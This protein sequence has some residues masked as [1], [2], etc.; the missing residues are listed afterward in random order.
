MHPILRLPATV[1]LALLAI[2]V[3]A[4]Q[5]TSYESTG[6]QQLPD[7]L[8]TRIQPELFNV[9]FQTSYIYQY[10]PG[11]NAAYS[12]SNSLSTTK[13]SVNSITATLFVGLRLWKGAELYINPELAGGSGLSGDKGMAGSANGETFRI[14]NLAPQLYLA[15]GYIRQTFPL[16]NTRDVA[17][18]GNRQGVE[19]AQ[20]Q[21]A[22]Y[23]PLNYLRFYLGKLSLADLFDNNTIGNS[24]RTQ[25][26]NWSFM[27]NGAWDFAANTR[28]Y[29]YVLAMEL[30]QHKTNYKIAAAAL[31]VVANGATLNTNFAN[32]IS[33]NAE[34]ATTTSIKNR[35]GHIRLLGFFNK[36]AMGSYQQSLALAP[37]GQRP[38][39]STQNTINGKLGF[40]L[41]IDQELSSLVSLF[42]R[43]G[44]NDGKNETWCFTEIDRTISAGLNIS[45][46]KWHRS[47]DNIGIAVVAN[48][49]SA[50]HR[51][52]LANGGLGFMLGDG[53][54]NYAPEFIGECYYNLRP[55]M[56]GIWFSAD[57]QFCVNPGYNSAR[58][59]VSIFSARL[60]VEL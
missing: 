25:F 56:A 53:K 13:E 21:L 47:S 45:G 18:A 22:G 49:I 36:A 20:N 10:K 4:Q 42:A 43:L 12:D 50:D 51:N 38:D 26:M 30:Q 37:L 29:T 8:S 55:V 60:H 3:H 6:L 40:G 28:G 17:I 48:G 11:F 52:Y 46:S 57:Y 27:N 16:K 24:P 15:R 23:T 35:N 2:V 44:W 33:L 39:V 1:C 54:L 9:H 59:P 31:P 7:T 58:G 41:N 19:S 32:S 14:G 5:N 34:A